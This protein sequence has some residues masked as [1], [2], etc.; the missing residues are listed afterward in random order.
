MNARLPSCQ[1]EAAAIKEISRALELISHLEAHLCPLILAKKGMDL[2]NN[3]FQEITS[4]LLESST[5][6]DPGAAAQV[7]SKKVK[8]INHEDGTTVKKKYNKD[9]IKFL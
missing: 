3:I 2:A 8:T 6:L 1:H 7:A 9:L 4:S 5:I